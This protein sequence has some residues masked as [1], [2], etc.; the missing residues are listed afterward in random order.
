MAITATET[1]AV[2]LRS[3][4]VKAWDIIATLDADTTAAVPHGMAAL[5][6]FDITKVKVWMQA[7][8]APARLSLWIVTSVDAANI[9][10]AKATTAASGD[11]GVQA[12]LFAEL[13]H[14]IL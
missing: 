1:P 12:Q 11:A 8:L 9:N 13:P 7:V 3:A 5:P 10:I 14:S 4:T 2:A 6:G